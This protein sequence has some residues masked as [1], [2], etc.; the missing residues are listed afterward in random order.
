MKKVAFNRRKGLVFLKRNTIFIFHLSSFIL[1]SSAPAEAQT[2]TELFNPAAREYI[3]GN[4]SVASNLVT[5]A[6]G[7]Y[8]TDEKLL[9][10]KE[11]IEQQ[12]EQQDQQNQQNQDQQDQQDQNQDQQNPNQDQQ[13]PNQDQQNQDQQQQQ[14][15]EQQEQEQQQADEQEPQEAQPP[16]AQPHQAGEMSPEEAQQLLDAMK[17]NEKDQR[18]DLRPYLGAPV[19]VDKDW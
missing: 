11:L 13:N 18:T 8:P 19:K 1:L 17:L 2:A 12:Q 5:Q 10:L 4:N 16:E 14:D 7:Q 3:Y 9:K 15:Q 6:L